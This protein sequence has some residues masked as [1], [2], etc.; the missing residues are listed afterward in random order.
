MILIAINSSIYHSITANLLPWESVMDV[1]W[2]KKCLLFIVLVFFLTGCQVIR[3]ED[4]MIL[5]ISQQN[6][7]EIQLEI[8][9]LSQQL[10]QTD[11]D[12][13]KQAKLHYRRA[14]LYNSL[15]LNIFAQNDLHHILAMMPNAIDVHNY[16][17][18]I[19]A[20]EGSTEQALT[21]F[22]TVLELDPDYEIS[23]LNRAILLYNTKH[24]SAAKDDA[25]V[26]YHRAPDKFYRLLWLY[27]IE[28]EI[29]QNQAKKLLQQRY[30]A[31]SQHKDWGDNILAFYLKKISERD[32]MQRVNDGITT[33]RAL[34]ERLC[35]MY[36]YLGKYYL[37]EKNVKRAE[38]MFKY[39]LASH[40]YNYIE[41]Q[42]ALFELE[43]L[44]Q[45]S[46]NSNN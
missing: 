2:F 20:S 4:K 31:M 30:E 8:I 12:N 38:M 46:T 23:R 6:N 14:A 10:H 43:K 13:N 17:G 44:K 26:F 39:A 40:I 3:Q 25:L 9:Q 33:D 16:L 34:A 11:L 7:D 42:Q 35:E 27:L 18:T 5:A 29:D 24:F 19:L 22:N 21:A 37:N 32:L 28:Y 45:Q 15:G 41:H 1:V 36:F